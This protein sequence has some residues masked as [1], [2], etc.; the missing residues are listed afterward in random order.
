MSECDRF[1]QQYYRVELIYP[2]DLRSP[3]LGRRREKVALCLRHASERTLLERERLREIKRKRASS[4]IG[5]RWYRYDRI[6]EETK[7]ACADAPKAAGEYGKGRAGARSVTA[8]SSPTSRVFFRTS[9]TSQ[10]SVLN[11]SRPI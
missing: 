4:T 2:D 9:V 1:V 10:T 3:G 7:E 5:R 8:H 11:A 6:D